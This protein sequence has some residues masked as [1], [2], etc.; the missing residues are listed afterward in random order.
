MAR[1]RG[2]DSILNYFDE[3][4]C[5]KTI[6]TYYETNDNKYIEKLYPDFIKIIHGMINKEFYHNSIIKD[7][8]LKKDAI[9]SCI[10]EIYKSLSTKKFKTEKG[11]LFAYLNRI[12]KNTL[13]Q[14]YI[15][16]I[17]SREIPMTSIN[18]S[19]ENDEND[20]T[21]EETIDFL[22]EKFKDEFEDMKN[23]EKNDIII[24][25]FM[26]EGKTKKETLK[27]CKKD[28]IYLYSFFKMIFDNTQEI[29]NNEIKYNKFFTFINNTL[30]LDKYKI[31]GFGSFTTSKSSHKK[32]LRFSLEKICIVMKKLMKWI[33]NTY[34]GDISIT[35]GNYKE[36][37]ILYISSDFKKY[38][39][40][41]T[42]EIE[43]SGIFYHKSI[44][45]NIMYIFTILA[46]GEDYYDNN[47]NEYNE[48][49]FM[50]AY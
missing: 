9:S 16:A 38:M 31:N 4:S 49:A 36:N 19:D 44:R 23:T 26:K 45:T 12:I 10:V 11:R 2:K 41:I 13:L 25:D 8:E 27:K 32:M 39:T 40:V 1:P 29:L 42:E 43:E 3:E 33:L 35:I 47:T 18:K 21:N 6:E 22:Q 15:K 30:E 50:E 48:F 46:N 34:D 24:Y 7:H 37:P 5:R 20:I 28:F 14:Y 17:K